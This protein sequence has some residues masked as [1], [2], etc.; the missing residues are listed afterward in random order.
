MYKHTLFIKFILAY[1]IFGIL[2][3]LLI[4]TVG[5]Q[6][7]EKRLEFSIGEDLRLPQSLKILWFR[8]TLLPA[9]CSP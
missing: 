9:I 8:A 1:L 3:F 7:V 2:G 6:M 4:A 5:S